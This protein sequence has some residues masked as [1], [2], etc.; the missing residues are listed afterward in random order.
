MIRRPPRSTRTDTLFPYT[1]LFRSVRRWPLSAD[2]G[3]A[4][5]DRNA[6]QAQRPP[7]PARRR[8][9]PVRAAPDAHLLHW[10]QLP[11]A[12]AILGAALNRHSVSGA[13]L[14]ALFIGTALERGKKLLAG[15]GCR[16]FIR[17]HEIARGLLV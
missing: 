6:R 17:D 12:R 2:G 16:V 7:L 13:G 11:P 15:S 10:W 1:T 14:S 4:A 3:C 8:R 5:C 9:H